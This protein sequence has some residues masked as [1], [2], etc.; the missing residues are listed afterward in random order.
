MSVHINTPRMS[1]FDP[2]GLPVRTV[3]YCRD[4][5]D[6]P[7]ESRI[8]RTL[9][10]AAGRAMKQWDPRLWL[11][12][13]D[14]R[15]TPANLTQVFALDATVIRSDSVDA[16]TQIE[17]KG[18]AAQTLFS[19]DS[20][21][22]RREIEHDNL[23]RPV[24]IFEE[25]TGVPRRC[26]ERLTY[27]HPG[28]GDQSRNQFGQLIRH[29]HPAGSVLFTAFA[30][31]GACTEDTRHFTLELL[32]PDWPERE[33]DRLRLLEPGVGA[34]SRWRHGAL[35][36]V[37]QQTDA[38]DNRHTF[39][40]TVDGR[41]RERRLQLKDEPEQT[42]VTDI[43]Y[44]AQ[45]SVTRETAG[46]GVQTTRTY[47]PEDGR[48]LDRRTEDADGGVLQHLMY[49]YDS[50]GNVLSIE[51]RAL[52]TR[53]FA[54]QRIEPVSRFFYDSLYRLTKACGWEA[55]TAS[56]GPQSMGRVDPA[57]ISNYQQT[58]K[59][60]ADG[61]LCELIHL[62]PQDH[63]RK[64]RPA[65]YSN[66]SLPYKVT[67]P[68]DAQIEAAYDRRG[69]LL[70]LEPGWLLSWN[71]RNQLQSVSPVERVSGINDSETYLYDG[72]SQRVRKIRSLLTN[73]RTLVADVRYLPGLELRTDNG[74]GERLQVITADGIRV[75][76]WESPPPWGV[77]IQYR[78][79]HVDHLGS[80]SLET[81]DDG[82]MISRET[83]HPFGTSAWQD[84]EF[85]YKYIR[86]SGK[87]RDATG[88]DY[89]DLRYYIPWLQHWLNPDPKG[90]IDGLNLYCMVANSPVTFFDSDGGG[91]TEAA[92]LNNSVDKQQALLSAVSS[93]AANTRN[94]IM[95]H[96]Y[97]RQRFQA[98]GRRIIT[99]LGSSAFSAGASAAGS[100]AGGG[101]GGLLGPGGAKLG[102]A[103]GEKA[104]SMAAD[105]LVSKVV[106]AYQLDRAINFKGNEM[107][108]KAFIESVE[109]KKRPGLATLGF[110]LAASDP[111]TPE[112][113]ARLARV[114]VDKAI[115]KVG[116]KLG[117]EAPG[118]IRT[119]IEFY[120]ASQGL[121]AETLSEA[122]EHTLAVIDMLEF[123][124]QAIK[125]EVAVS[126]DA[127]A[128]V[129]EKVSELSAQ[130]PVVVQAL[131]RNQDFIALV[132]PTPYAGK[133]HSL[134]RG[135]GAKS[136]PSRQQS[137]G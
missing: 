63:G 61:N 59:Y 22:T 132:A 86:Y 87:E 28:S 47:R 67:P 26:V 98:L 78:Y 44:N 14:D 27:G 115:D 7:V 133:R 89:F 84:G 128:E 68:T 41:L 121:D 76:R 106:D 96:L 17:L 123:R 16:G 54:N 117:S 33:A 29:D 110:E 73:A 112:G 122:H 15:L 48:L 51:D 71:L 19:W 38:R 23:L 111:R 60:D 30:I 46:N 34:T 45:G 80:V 77:N 124:T 43:R 57:A 130:T 52:P 10:D 135:A 69:N 49:G 137:F 119:G 127:T 103:A 56:Q 125:D 6:G 36:D 20:R 3:D 13:A 53:Y 99:Q 11:S 4:I 85:S 95:N 100:A 108:P 64:L 105:R 88:L 9:H 39:E 65:S 101:I 21:Q 12:Q 24:A 50:T 113:R 62:G 31:I 131:N 129:F 37:L 25:G 2:R 107:N 118:F 35:G 91:K 97:A 72:S 116:G 126:D 1:V 18:L 55:G 104:A 134:K 42:L 32:A 92:E 90:M 109:P 66:R 120:H 81:A 75:L 5:E 136:S 79:Q 102:A 114:V 94:S 83:F 58:Y 40:L 8:N 74:T 82:A 70:Q 93:A